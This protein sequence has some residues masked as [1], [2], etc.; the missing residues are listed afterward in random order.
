MVQVSPT[1]NSLAATYTDFL[2]YEALKNRTF[3]RAKS[4]LNA[5]TSNFIIPYFLSPIKIGTVFVYFL[6]Y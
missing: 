6:R 1:V 5:L 2:T 3:N 4:D